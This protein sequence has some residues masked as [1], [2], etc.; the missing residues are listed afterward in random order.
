MVG[1]MGELSGRGSSLGLAARDGAQLAVEQVNADGGV[2]GR[3]VHLEVVDDSEGSSAIPAALQRLA[4]EGAVAVVGP[5]TS[6]SAVIAAP[7]M[8]TLRIPLVSPTVSTGDLTAKADYFLRIYPDNTFAGSQLAS[9]SVLRDGHRRVAV[10]Y[11]LSNRSYTQTQYLSFKQAA[12]RLGADIVEVTT[13]TSGENV[14]YTSVAQALVAAKPDC[15][16][17]IA[18]SIDTGMLC[19]RIRAAG[20]SAHLI[21]TPWSG[22]DGLIEAGGRSVE[23]LLYLDTI[24]P[25]SSSERFVAFVE[26]FEQRYGYTPGFSAV[27]AYEAMTFVLDAAQKQPTPDGIRDGLLAGTHQGLQV[28]IELDRFG[29]ARRPYFPMTVHQGALQ[30]ARQ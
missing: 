8:D 23:G 30:S 22:N 26:A 19:Q 20:S 16:L 14:D 25:R 7:I 1:F 13:F 12:E 9:E 4:D 28:P 18:N 5:V 24:D 17:M 2:G 6:A 29:D 3:Q 10:A 27:H 11:D 21:A 15:I